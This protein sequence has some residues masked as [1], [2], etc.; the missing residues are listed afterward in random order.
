MVA[1]CLPS[2][3]YLYLFFYKRET[4]KTTIKGIQG[5]SFLCK[6]SCEPFVY[7]KRYYW[8]FF[9]N[10]KL[11]VF[12]TRKQLF[13]YTRTFLYSHVFIRVVF[14]TSCFLYELFFIL[15]FV[16]NHVVF[17]GSIFWGYQGSLCTPL[18]VLSLYWLPTK[19]FLF[20]LVTSTSLFVRLLLYV[21]CK[22]PSS[23]SYKKQLV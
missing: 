1:I 12:Y 2:L 15:L 3:R 22:Y 11:V 14:Y 21:S 18:G 20:L 10:K 9:T 6:V 16:G 5:V 17:W 7:P 8:Y 19:R 13:F 23:L 4:K